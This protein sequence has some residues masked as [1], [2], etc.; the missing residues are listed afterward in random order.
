MKY[1]VGVLIYCFVVVSGYSQL[2]DLTWFSS[3]DVIGPDGSTVPASPGDESS[4]A[5]AQLI[6]STS[7]SISAP[8]VTD[9]YGVGSNNTFVDY[10]W[11]GR[12][13]FDASFSGTGDYIVDYGLAATDYVFVRIW[14]QPTTGSGQIPPSTD[15]GGGNVGWYYTDS[16]IGQIQNLPL[17]ATGRELDVGSITQGD[18]TFIPEPGTIALSLLGLGVL[19]TRRFVKK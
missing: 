19:I 6:T 15:F 3:T 1:I 9:P 11:C 5:L 13:A 17:T 14:N 7:G 4:G 12:G 8:D 18:W 2:N 10:T 16:A